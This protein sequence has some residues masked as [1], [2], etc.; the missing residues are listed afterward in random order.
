M[1]LDESVLEHRL[2]VLGRAELDIEQRLQKL[3][4]VGRDAAQRGEL[5]EADTIWNMFETLRIE[6]RS[7]QSEITLIERD[8]YGFRS[9]RR[10]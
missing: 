7:L 6:L 3:R 4:V 8:L 5:D 9:R 10:K 1:V 2:L